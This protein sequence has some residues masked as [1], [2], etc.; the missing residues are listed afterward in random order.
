M[1]L[2]FYI[3]FK[4]YVHDPASNVLRSLLLLAALL[5]LLFL[6]KFGAS[7]EL[8]GFPCGQLAQ[9][10][11][12]HLELPLALLLQARALLLPLELALFDPVLLHNSD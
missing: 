9:S 11:L 6:L 12:L 8:G 3:S 5:L 4:P 2:N 10:V 1:K 7:S